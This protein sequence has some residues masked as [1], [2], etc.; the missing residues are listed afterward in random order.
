M[1]LI[2]SLF[3]LFTLNLSL[4]YLSVLLTLSFYDFITLIS[5]YSL[6]SYLVIARLYLFYQPVVSPLN[7]VA[8]LINAISFGCFYSFTT[9]NLVMRFYFVILSTVI[10]M[11]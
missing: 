6:M 11:I 8:N 9:I 7:Q 10:T 5:H 4:N 1:I 3:Y 2:F